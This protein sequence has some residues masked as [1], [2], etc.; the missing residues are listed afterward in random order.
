MLLRIVDLFDRVKQLE[1]DAVV[2]GG[3]LQG[4]YVLRETAS[5]VARARIEKLIA[6]PR[7][8]ADAV[9]NRFDVRAQTLREIGELVH[10]RDAR[11]QHRIRRIFGELGGAHVH[12]QHSLMAP[13]KR[14]VNAAQRRDGVR[15]VAADDDAIGTHEIVDGRALLEELRIGDDGEWHSDIARAQLVG[16]C[17]ADVVGGPHGH[18]RLVDDDLGRRHSLADVAGC[19]QD[20]AHIRAAVLVGRGTDRDEL[21]GTMRDRC[22]DVG[23]EAQPP[24]GD[25]ALDHQLQARLVNRYAAGLER[26]DLSLVDVQAQDVVADLREA[27]S[28]DEPDVAR[29]NHRDFHCGVPRAR[30]IWAS[31]ASGSTARV[32]GLPTTR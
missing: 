3:R 10:E 30:L 18:R 15:V 14:R 25:V 13:L 6:D 26:F 5:A 29:A 27:G 9:A 20:V 16:N 1:R 2:A 23:G 4:P 7:I 12:H 11:R 8:G 19:L 28:G 17:G 31:A 24:R 32:I 21:Q 22:V